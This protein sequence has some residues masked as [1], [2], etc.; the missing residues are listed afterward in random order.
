MAFDV[1]SNKYT[2]IFSAAMVVVVALVLGVAAEGLKPFQ[3]SNIRQEKMQS[4]LSSAGI[5]VDRSEAQAN[6]DKYITE[7]ILLD[8]KGEISTKDVS[9]FDVDVLKE[10]RS[11][12]AEERNYPLFI[13]S[14]DNGEK[15]YI[16]PLVGKGLWGPVWGYIAL[17]EDM[18]TI[19][20][21]RFD[22]KG[23]TPG[24]GAEITMSWFQEPFVGKKI[25]KEDGTFA[26][27][28]VI[29]GGAK[30]DDMHGVDAISGGTITSNGVSN[31][32]NDVLVVY[33]PYFQQN[34]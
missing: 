8:A 14:L 13:C 33:V 16:I 21:A 2:F 18:N 31:M 1:N 3:K 23:E 4:I 11:L 9:P 22:H 7:Q 10:S 20:G 15:N 25:F 6:F 24:L 17:A 30:P 32:L 5:D 12:P 27:V 26:S 34:S 28:K 19:T 29:K